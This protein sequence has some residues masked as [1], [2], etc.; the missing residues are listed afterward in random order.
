MRCGRE[1]PGTRRARPRTPTGSPPS[2]GGP[3]Q[4]RRTCSRARTRR[5][6]RRAGPWCLGEVRPG[7]R[8]LAER[9]PA[10]GQTLPLSFL[11]PFSA[12]GQHLARAAGVRQPLLGDLQASTVCMPARDWTFSC[13]RRSASSQ[14]HGAKLFSPAPALPHLVRAPPGSAPRSRR[15]SPTSSRAPDRTSSARCHRAMSGRRHSPGLPSGALPRPCPRPRGRSRDD[16]LDRALPRPGGA[17]RLRL[18]GG[19]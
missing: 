5:G 15:P 10:Y 9:Q 4:R 17:V 8:P 2:S 3:R 7:G 6:A 11:A 12:A 1:W 18:G 19:R 14:Y 13:A 16:N